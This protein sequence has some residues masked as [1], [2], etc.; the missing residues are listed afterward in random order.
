MKES[1]FYFRFVLITSSYPHYSLFL[2][3]Y[4]IINNI[5]QLNS[6]QLV[7]VLFSSHPW[8]DFF[9]FPT[10]KLTLTVQIFFP[11][12]LVHDSNSGCFFFVLFLVVEL[13][14]CSFVFEFFD[15]WLTTKKFSVFSVISSSTIWGF[16]YC[17]SLR[18]SLFCS[19]EMKVVLVLIDCYHAHCVGGWCLRKWAWFVFFCY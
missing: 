14:P 16:C 11:F 17:F 3:Q 18:V 12:G 13:E 2:R 4:S 9:L 5:S 15:P 1:S 6:T 10:Q 7:L 19:A 8:F